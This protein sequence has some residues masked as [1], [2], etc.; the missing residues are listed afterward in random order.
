MSLLDYV[1]NGNIELTREILPFS[2]IDI[3]NKALCEVVE[4][5][6]LEMVRLLLPR[7]NPMAWFNK[8]LYLACWCGNFQIVELLLPV[9]NPL[10]LDRSLRAASFW[11]HI[12]IVRLLLPYIDLETLND[13]MNDAIFSYT[14]EI[15]LVLKKY[16]YEQNIKKIIENT[17][18]CVNIVKKLALP[19]EIQ[20][21]IGAWGWSRDIILYYETPDE[22]HNS[23]VRMLSRIL[24]NRN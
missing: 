10:E 5:E 11:G 19:L 16:I 21:I 17:R 13:V 24:R 15:V 12:E 8:A 1:H 3:I 7:S 9:S 23:S 6:D 4:T 18:I 20:C 2:D 14:M 22:I